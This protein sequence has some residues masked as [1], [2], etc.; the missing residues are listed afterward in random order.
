VAIEEPDTDI[1][2]DAEKWL[3]REQ[4]RV[5]LDLFEE[6]CGRRPATLEEVREWAA[7][8]NDK[9]LRSRVNCRLDVVLDCYTA[10]PPSQPIP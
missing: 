7:T 3:L 2:H 5:M 10:T 4:A 1:I 8:Q 6:D 9:S